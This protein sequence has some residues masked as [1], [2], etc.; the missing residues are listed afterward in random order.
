MI[1]PN[2]NPP[3]LWQFDPHHIIYHYEYDVLYRIL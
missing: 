1:L 3:I 2:N